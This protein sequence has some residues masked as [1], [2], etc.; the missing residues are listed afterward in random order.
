MSVQGTLNSI[1]HVYTTFNNIKYNILD[2]IIGKPYII[3]YITSINF[4]LYGGNYF[5]NK[6]YI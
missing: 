4:M 3:I 5:I 6:K 1:L 2:I